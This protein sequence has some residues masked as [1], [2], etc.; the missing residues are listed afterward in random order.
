MTRRGAALRA[1][2]FLAG[3]ASGGAAPADFSRYVAVGD[4]YTAGVVSNALVETHQA[5]SFPAI[6]ARQA[7]VASFEQPLVTEPGIP[8]ELVVLSLNPAAII[9][10]KSSTTGALRNG[11]LTRAYNN[12]GIPNT[13]AG[14]ILIRTSDAGGLHDLIL[15]G[16]GTAISQALSLQ[17]TFVTL[18]VGTDEVMGAVLR[19]GVQGLPSV[20]AFRASYQELVRALKG[21]GVTVIAG[22]IPD[23]TAFPFATTIK[24]YVVDP[25]TG[26][27][28]R[29]GGGNVPLLG[30]GGPVA[31]DSRITLVASSL[32]AQGVGVPEAQ[33][34]RGTPLPAEVIL[35]AAEIASIQGRIGALN[36]VISDVCLAASVPVVDLAAFH[37]SLTTAG[38]RIG[39]ITVSG[40]FL[41][42]GFFSYDGV[43]PTELGYALIANE[44]V[45][46]LRAAGS[47]L[48][49]VDLSPY[50]GVTASARRRAA[51]PSFELSR[52]GAAAILELFARRP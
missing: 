26:G 34:G 50:I 31:P 29:V 23:V 41:T 18:W 20:D 28:V 21:N 35:D 33:G 51:P 7:A 42:G 22:N 46:A 24:P 15:R 12:L 39:G 2:L 17:P 5:S 49:Q 44:W 45:A 9:A 16:R 3:A 4:S 11:S 30:P 13:T 37:A 32:L 10:P 6:L 25:A 27:P 40:V 38:R 43:H 52:E 1:V 47:P 36:Q 19:G 8:A 48:P 14:D